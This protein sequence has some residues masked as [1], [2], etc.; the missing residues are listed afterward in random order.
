MNIAIIGTG[1]MLDRRAEP[2][3]SDNESNLYEICGKENSLSQK[4]TQKYKCNY[5]SDWKKTLLNPL[6]DIV[7]VC[8]PPSLHREITEYALNN[9]KHVLCEKPLAKS[10]QEAQSMI[11][12]MKQSG[13]ILKCGFNHRHHSAIEE[14]KKQFDSG[15]YGEIISCNANYGICGRPGYENEWRANP[16]FAVGG[17]FGEQGVH[18]ID[19]FRYFMGDIEEVS[20]MTSVAYFKK[21]TLEDNGVAILRSKEGALA[22]MISSL[23]HWKNKFYFEINCSNGYIIIDGLG[24]SYGEQ[25]LIL[26]KKDFNAPFSDKIIYYR[27]KDKSWENEWKEFKSSIKN[28]TTPIGSAIDGLEATK[29]LSAAYEAEKTNS[30]IKI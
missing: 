10:V 22:S 29:I 20:C 15:K 5:S 30:V 2:I 8:T 27:G 11:D 28:N 4:I 6:I 23:T 19:L 18:I 16:S 25:K 21:Q 14:A 1:L 3:I 9:N 24:G 17:H 12:V 26:G 13:K 7:L